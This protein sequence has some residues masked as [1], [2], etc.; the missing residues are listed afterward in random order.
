MRAA[1]RGEPV[2]GPTARVAAPRSG[3]AVPVH[4]L[5]RAAF[6]EGLHGRLLD[7]ARGDLP[8]LPGAE[9]ELLAAPERDAQRLPCLVRDRARHDL[10]SYDP[11][12]AAVAR[13]TSS[14]SRSG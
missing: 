10:S 4:D 8:A 1:T 2:R 9:K 7:G 11:R 6:D 5:D 13:A 14:P 12:D 3:V